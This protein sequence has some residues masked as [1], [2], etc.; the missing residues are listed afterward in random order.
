MTVSTG[1]PTRSKDAVFYELRVGSFAD[2]DGDGI[3]DGDGLT[4][5]LDY[6]AELSG[7]CFWLMPV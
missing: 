5:K 2:G 4:A 6:L 3:G 1:D 7:D